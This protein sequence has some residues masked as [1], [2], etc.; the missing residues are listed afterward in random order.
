MQQLPRNFFRSDSLTP[1]PRTYPA[2][3]GAEPHQGEYHDSS[4]AMHVLCK[5]ELRSIALCEH[6]WQALYV[7]ARGP[8]RR[9]QGPAIVTP[10]STGTEL[11][12]DVQFLKDASHC[13][14]DL[15]TNICRA[16]S[17]QIKP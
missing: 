12:Q 8:R 3:K 15:A 11:S 17:M 2:P 1:D 16:S 13:L 9:M 6:I 4:E 7:Q 10:M 14:T 5:C